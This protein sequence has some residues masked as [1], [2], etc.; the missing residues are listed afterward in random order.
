MIYICVVQIL[1]TMKVHFYLKDKEATTETP[2]F[3]TVRYS[4]ERMRIY[5]TKSI[6]PKQ[7]N[8]KEQ[9][10]RQSYTGYANFNKWLL[11]IEKQVSQIDTDWK[12]ENADKKI[13]P[14][15]PKD[16]LKE[17]LRR[18]LSKE[19]T[20]EKLEGIK[21]TFWGYY[22]TFLNRMETG[23]RVHSK[24]GTP[25]SKRFIFQF[26]NLK[27]HLKNFENKKKFKLT[28]ENIDLGFYNKFLEYQTADLKQSPNTIGKMITNLKVF[29][30][31]AYEEGKTANNVFTHRK[32]KTIN[33]QSDTVYLD[34]DEI[35]EMQALNLITSPRL[36][37][38]RDMFVIGCYTGLRFS[39]L[40]RIGPN[41]IND[42]MI[43]LKQ[44][45]TGG[46]VFIPIT[47]DVLTLLEK[48]EFKMPKI[49]NQKFNDYLGKV[50]ENCE[51]LK[52]EITT[53]TIKG[54]IKT[55]VTKP[56]HDFV[57][58]H[59]ARRSFA[60]N[61]YKAGDLTVNEIMAITGHKTEKAFYKYIRE[62]SKG[63]AERIKEKFKQREM[64]LQGR[65]ILRA[66]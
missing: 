52:K 49:S 53:V 24:N 43:E 6:N 32:F 37:R 14:P 25:L 45:K 31:E 66:V 63:T 47:N 33:F 56:K 12:N 46:V 8:D 23:S 30:R 3:L 19:T 65:T 40:V 7:W 42:G 51:L 41:N 44:Q 15:I 27:R 54:G 16:V 18:Y 1:H 34:W 13:I 60:T 55:P 20:E 26:H 61:E 9:K 11:N 38:V 29:L 28:F 59:T 50:A 36:E 10:A 4:A 5:T 17:R 21:R 35:K 62:T 64:R 57:S 48:Y 2:I 39:D 58:S 22:D